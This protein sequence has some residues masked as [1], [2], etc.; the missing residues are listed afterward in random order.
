MARKTK[1]EAAATREALLDAAEEMF[2]EHGVARTSLEQIARQAGMTRGAVYWHFKN[3]GD[4]FRAMLERVHMPFQDLVD[5][6]EALE[7]DVSSLEAIRLA[8]L[9]GLER[10][11]QNPR[12]RR[13]H[14]ILIHRCEFFSD[15]DPIAMQQEIA[16]ECRDSLYQHLLISEEQQMLVQGLS[17]DVATDLLQ[18]TL[19]G[20]FHEWIRD[21]SRF[22]IYERGVPLVNQLTSM[23][24]RSTDTS[25][26]N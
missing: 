3:K 7:H 11:E 17:P 16:D 25:G 9:K 26:A 12:A 1:A 23:M 24:R 18:A 13:V 8:C 21:P 19:A 2:M 5:E 10:F 6:I 4:M 20:L 14:A 15:I 22:S